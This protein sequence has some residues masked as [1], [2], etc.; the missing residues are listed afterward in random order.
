MNYTMKWRAAIGVLLLAVL[1][2]TTASAQLTTVRGREIE[3]RS[4][5]V[6]R[7]AIPPLVRFTGTLL[8]SNHK[9]GDGFH[10]LTVLAG[11]YKWL[12]WVDD[13]ETLT[14]PNIGEMILGKI[15]PPELHFTGPEN[16]LQ[17]LQTA[18]ATG[19][20]VTVE[21]RLYLA[22]RMF[23]VTAANEGAATAG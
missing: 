22:D 8:P 18:E 2:V 10:T 23:A 17:V 1:G 19:T 13:V 14:E 6:P 16:L 5:L 4:P 20:P 11:N 15:F 21:G 9:S 3:V 12:F 7:L